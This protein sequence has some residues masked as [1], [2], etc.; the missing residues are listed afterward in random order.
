MRKGVVTD[1]EETVKAIEAAT[2][3]AERMAGVH[4]SHVY[5]G[6]TGEHIQSTNNRGVVAVSGDDREVIASRRQARRRRVEDHQ[7]RGRPPDHPR[8]AAPLH[9]RRTG[10]RHR[11]GRDVGQPARSR[12][13]HRHRRLDVHRQRAQVRAPRRARAGRDRVRAARIIGRDAARR[14]R[15]TSA[16]CCSTSAAERPTSRSSPAAAS[17]TARR[18]R[19]AE[20]SSPTTSRSACKTTFAEAENVKRTYGSGLIHPDE[21]EQVV[22]SEDRSTA[23]ARAR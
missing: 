14:K 10:R 9:D 11:S 15:N 13:A 5:V 12:H 23:A 17:C 19:S 21:A 4:I 22:S 1:L 2:E 3:R 16:A 18:F 7:P 20:T 6:V 8:A